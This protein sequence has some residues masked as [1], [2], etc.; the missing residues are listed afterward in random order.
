MLTVCFPWEL[1]KMV[2]EFN[3][4]CLCE[5]LINFLLSNKISALI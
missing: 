3:N 5:I 4:P 2:M 1:K